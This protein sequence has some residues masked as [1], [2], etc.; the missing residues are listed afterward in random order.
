MGTASGCTDTPAT[1]DATSRPSPAR[2]ASATPS[3]PG[4]ASDRSPRPASGSP[5]GRWSG[6]P[7]GG[8]QLRADAADED[9]CATVRT[10]FAETVRPHCVDEEPAEPLLATI[11]TE[12]TDSIARALAPGTNAAFGEQLRRALV[13]AVDARRAETAVLGDVL[14]CEERSLE[15]ADDVID[16]VATW[17]AGAEETPLTDLG[18]DE[19]RGR[20]ETLAAHRDRCAGC[21]RERQ[22]FLHTT[23]SRR[24]AVGL[25]HRD[26]IESLYDD[27]PVAYP[28]LSTLVRLDRT[29]VACQ[30]TVRE[31]LVC[32]G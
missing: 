5:T 2:T 8:T 32:R 26:L 4:R 1:A 25:R 30:R 24:A 19:L 18:F 21:L 10:A 28:V 31:H 3:V 14:E 13:E 7:D 17:I 12:L 20:H 23:T 11:A 16:E 15:A 22:A 9:R 29:C 27:V 6:R